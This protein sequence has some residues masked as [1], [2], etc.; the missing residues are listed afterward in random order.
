MES[1]RIDMEE[2]YGKMCSTCHK[3]FSVSK[4]LLFWRETGRTCLNKADVWKIIYRVAAD[5]ASHFYF[6]KKVVA[7]SY[8]KVCFFLI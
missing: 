1:G 3:R 8:A 6:M 4:V 5:N 7:R 2:M